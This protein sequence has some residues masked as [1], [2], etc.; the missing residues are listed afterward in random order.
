MLQCTTVPERCSDLFEGFMDAFA[1]LARTF[2]PFF[3]KVYHQIYPIVY[4]LFSFLF[5][6]GV[7]SLG[8]TSDQSE[9]LWQTAHYLSKKLG[10]VR[11]PSDFSR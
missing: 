10:P 4:S 2:A 11:L 5:Q 6:L 9:R 7:S 3:T 8:M 1:R